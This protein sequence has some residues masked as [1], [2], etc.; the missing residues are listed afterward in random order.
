[1]LVALTKGHGQNAPKEIEIRA[2]FSVGDPQAVS[3]GQ[4]QGVSVVVGNC[5]E[6]ELLVLEQSLFGGGI[7]AAHLEAPL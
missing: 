1:M 4:D 3:I 2:T 6:Q 5:T 7:G